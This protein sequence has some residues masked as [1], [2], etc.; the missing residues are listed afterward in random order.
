MRSTLQCSK[1]AHFQMHIF[2]KLIISLLPMKQI[3]HPAP[4]QASLAFSCTLSNQVQEKIFGHD[5]EV[6]ASNLL[7]NYLE[8]SIILVILV[9]HCRK[10]TWQHS[11]RIR[12]IEKTFSFNLIINL[13]MQSFPI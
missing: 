2:I 9:K 1:I 11:A 6:P 12:M 10:N 5:Y 7:K 13:N 3:R 8:P 4:T